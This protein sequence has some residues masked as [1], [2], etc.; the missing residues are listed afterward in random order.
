M[1]RR[2][3]G[4]C[5]GPAGCLV[6]GARCFFAI[7]MAQRPW[8]CK[9]R[10]WAHARRSFCSLCLL[11]LHRRKR[12]LVGK[13]KEQDELRLA[14]AMRISSAQIAQLRVETPI[15]K[16]PQAWIVAD[17]IPSLRHPGCYSAMAPDTV[18]SG[19]REVHVGAGCKSAPEVHPCRERTTVAAGSRVIPVCP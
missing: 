19:R 17:R 14:R 5:R 8:A 7:V 13:L 11:C 15:A 12:G 10:S 9:A 16:R 2:P 6:C 3:A 4:A 18:V 1:H